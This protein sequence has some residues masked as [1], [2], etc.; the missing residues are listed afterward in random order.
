VSDPLVLG[1][2][3]AILGGQPP[4]VHLLT[5]M[6]QLFPSSSAYQARDAAFLAEAAHCAYN[7][8][9]EIVAQAARWNYPH[10]RFL[11]QGN[12][13][14][15]IMAN[16]QRVVLVFRGTEPT[17]PKDWL[18][19]TKLPL[20]EALGGRVHGG[21]WQDWRNV[22]DLVVEQVRRLRDRNQE[23]WITGHSLGGALSVLAALTLVTQ[24][25]SVN[26]VYTFGAPRIGDLD[27][28][29]NYNS[30][31]QAQTLRLVNHRDMVP[32]V[33]PL[34]WGYQ[35]VG[36]M[37]YFNQQGQLQQSSQF[38]EDMLETM[39]GMD[40]KTLGDAVRDH[41][42]HAYRACI[43]QNAIGD[44]PQEYPSNLQLA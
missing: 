12:T 28:S 9:Q 30:Y 3:E 8:P 7:N 20:R 23:L 26:G 42:M 32:R 41:D 10:F 44:S 24:D 27:F 15:Y 14:A 22:A 21:F 40:Y 36:Q 1:T 25:Q 33:P 31:L 17:S 29:N 2:I 34:Q 39:R 16:D 43:A 37:I 5:T 4:F 18:T 35:H 11:E 6:K 19:N 38:W 13:Q